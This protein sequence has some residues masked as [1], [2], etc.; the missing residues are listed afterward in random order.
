[1]TRKRLIV[2]LLNALNT[3]SA[4]AISKPNSM[5]SSMSLWNSVV[6]HRLCFLNLLVCQ[7]KVLDKAALAMSMGREL[8]ECEDHGEDIYLNRTLDA[9]IVRVIESADSSIEFSE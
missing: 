3:G 9:A 5:P 4:F 6:S 7:L 2:S 1:M 8:C